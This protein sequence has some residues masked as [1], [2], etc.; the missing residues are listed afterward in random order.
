M[1]LEI[2][3]PR[4][5]SNQRRGH[6]RVSFLA[7]RDALKNMLDSGLS[8][9]AIYEA[10]KDHLDIGY[11]QFTK[12]MTRYIKQNQPVFVRRDSWQ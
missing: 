1:K 6:G 7:H 5:T 12:Y 9:T 2:S 4:T 11:T 3:L 10:Y 8:L